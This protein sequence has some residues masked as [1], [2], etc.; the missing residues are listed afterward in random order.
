MFEVIRKIN[1]QIS[2]NLDS[3]QVDYFYV[4][5]EAHFY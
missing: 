1:L 2:V 5:Y 3:A 4:K